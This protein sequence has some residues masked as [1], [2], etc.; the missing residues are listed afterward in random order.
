M[1][2][3]STRNRKEST[4]EKKWRQMRKAS[5]T[6]SPSTSTDSRSNINNSSTSNKHQKTRMRS[7]CLRPS[8]RGSLSTSSQAMR[9][10]PLSINTNSN[11]KLNKNSWIG[12]LI[13]VR[14]NR[15]STARG[16]GREYNTRMKME[17][18]WCKSSYPMTNW[19]AR[20]KMR[21]NLQ[22]TTRVNRTSS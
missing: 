12:T 4:T 15:K 5:R 6:A 17:I 14:S 20:E 10:L 11:F 16:R 13:E 8:R 3:N 22:S 7:S 9:I 21:T 19:A 2:R 1:V 18:W